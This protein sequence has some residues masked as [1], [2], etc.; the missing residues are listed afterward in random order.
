MLDGIVDPAQDPAFILGVK[1][2][3]GHV[4]RAIIEPNMEASRRRP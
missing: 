1:D 4:L 2:R 3:A